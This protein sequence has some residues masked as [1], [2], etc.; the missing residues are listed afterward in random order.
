MVQAMK[1]KDQKLT[2]PVL[3][4]DP[5]DELPVTTAIHFQHA[6]T[7]RAASATFPRQ[8]TTFSESPSALSAASQFQGCP[9]PIP[10]LVPKSMDPEPPPLLI[11][12]TSTSGQGLAN[13]SL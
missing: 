7:I 3:Q 6:P 1:P 10:S 4:G 12:G 9:T 11:P 8:P 13:A 2:K 5:E